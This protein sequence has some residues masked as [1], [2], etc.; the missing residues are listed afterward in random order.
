MHQQTQLQLRQQLFQSQ[1]VVVEQKILKDLLL[2]FQ[3]L[4]QQVGVEEVIITQLAELVVQVVEQVEIQQVEEQEIH[5]L[6]VQHKDKMEVLL[7][8]VVLVVGP[9][10]VVVEEQEL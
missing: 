9:A 8:Q 6:L 5:P 4:V 3:Q 7:Y 2:H 1:L 10:Q